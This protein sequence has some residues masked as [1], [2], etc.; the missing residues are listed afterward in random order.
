MGHPWHLVGILQCAGSSPTAKNWF[1]QFCDPFEKLEEP[2]PFL[3]QIL[4]RVPQGGSG[5]LGPWLLEQAKIKT[6]LLPWGPVRPEP[7]WSECYRART[8]IA[9]HACEKKGPLFLML[10]LTCCAKSLEGENAGSCPQH[11]PEEGR[12]GRGCSG[13]L[14]SQFLPQGQSRLSPEVLEAFPLGLSP[15]GRMSSLQSQQGHVFTHRQLSI[16]PSSS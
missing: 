8:E 7:R 11:H 14:W 1:T 13:L 9:P 12:A 5:F 3:C 15:T 16:P 2:I 6:T 4:G 10:I